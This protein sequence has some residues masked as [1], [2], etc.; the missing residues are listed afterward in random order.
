[1][2]LGEKITHLRVVNNMSQEE[3]AKALNVTRQSISKWESG[4]TLPQIDKVKEICDLFKITA[5]ELIDDSVV[6]HRGKQLIPSIGED[7]KTK[8][9]GTDGFRGEVNTVLTADHAYKIGRFLG[10]FYGNPKFNAQKPGY[11]A[12]IDIGKDTRRSSYMLE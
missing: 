7:I 6:I 5:D 2:T 1:M 10:W 3:L 4:E 11:R 12:R 9:F 8:Y